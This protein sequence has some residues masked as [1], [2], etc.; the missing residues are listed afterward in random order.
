M[1]RRALFLLILLVADCGIAKDKA[2]FPQL[3][4]KAKYVFVTNYF[5]DNLA[6]P[7]VPAVDRQ[8]VTD[9]Q[10]AI[11]DWGRYTL[12]FDRKAA[13]LILLVRKGR[14][15]EESQGIIVHAGSNMPKPGIGPINDADAGDPDDMLAVYNASTGIDTAPVWRDRMSDGLNTP[16]VKLVRELRKKVDEADK[17][18]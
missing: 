7:R 16:D 17:K 2:A 5:S 10:D 9:V 13:D 6:D 18:P 11:R 15:H 4:V 3:I 8:A 14:T 12:V 1:T